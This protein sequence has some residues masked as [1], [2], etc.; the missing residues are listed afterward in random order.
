MEMI[1]MWW[2]WTTRPLL[3]RVS[4]YSLLSR[5]SLS[6]RLHCGPG[7]SRDCIRTPQRG[8]AEVRHRQDSHGGDNPLFVP[9]SGCL[10]IRRRRRWPQSRRTT[11]TIP[12]SC[13]LPHGSHRPGASTIRRAVERRGSTLPDVSLYRVAA[14][15]PVP[16]A[17]SRPL[18]SRRASPFWSAPAR[19]ASK[20]L[21]ERI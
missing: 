2:F 9:V 3:R 14:G 7:G 1:F 11:S 21:L 19:P 6:V 16:A 18:Q 12:S 13:L 5:R 17:R 10:W 20:I 8:G 4:G 15:I